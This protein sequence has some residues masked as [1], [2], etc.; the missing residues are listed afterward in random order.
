[1]DIKKLSRFKKYKMFKINDLLF[2]I[3]N[4]FLKT[5]FGKNLIKKL[6]NAIKR[7]TNL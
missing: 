2:I 1:M 3:Y 7:K 4:I 5:S 6:K